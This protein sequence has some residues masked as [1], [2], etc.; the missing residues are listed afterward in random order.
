MQLFEPTSASCTVG[1]YASLSVCLPVQVGYSLFHSD[2][3]L[4]VCAFHVCESKGG[5][6]VNVNLHFFPLSGCLKN[7]AR[8]LFHPPLPETKLNSIQRLQF[9]KVNKIF[10]QFEKPFW[11]VGSGS[12]KLAWPV[13][14]AYTTNMANQWYRKIFSFDEVMNNPTVLVAWISGDE[15]EYM[16]TLKDDDVIETCA[17]IIRQFLGNPSIPRPTKMVRS[18]WCTNPFTRGSYTY[19]GMGSDE[20]D[21]T[22]LAQPVCSDDNI[23]RLLFAGEATSLTA[24][25]T[26][27]GA[28]STGLQQAKKILSL[29][30]Q[31]TKS[32]K[33]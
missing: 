19:I 12:I 6:Y 1:S 5:L 20:S 9:G 28:R 18:S 27:H 16:E 26:M 30:A 15:A 21:I 10:L 3:F 23:P 14:E 33:L 32:A 17:Q 22:N 31:N 11:K 13:S 2:V 7:S 4:F 8:S 25:S 24:Y 29:Y